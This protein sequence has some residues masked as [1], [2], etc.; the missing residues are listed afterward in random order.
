MSKQSCDDNNQRVENY[1]S[2]L[3]DD[4]PE[5]K[6]SVLDGRYSSESISDEKASKDKVSGEKA[7]DEKVLEKPISE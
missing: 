5:Q 7:S 1:L 6:E 3:L 2:F 4:I